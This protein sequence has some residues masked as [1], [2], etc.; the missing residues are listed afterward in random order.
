MPESAV[1][2]MMVECFAGAPQSGKTERLVRRACELAQDGSRVAF[3]CARFGDVVPARERL[4]AYGADGVFA[5]TARQLSLDVLA[6]SQARGLF[7][8]AP[9]VLEPYE[10]QLLLEDLKVSQMRNRRL[11]QVLTYLYAG[12][13]NLSD[14]TWETTP[15]EDVVI[16]RL[17]D[18]LRFYGGVLA[19]EASNL[20]LK[21][22]RLEGAS[23]E[24]AWDFVV[25]DDYGL[26]NRASQ[27]LVRALAGRG[28]V[29]S[30]C[31]RPGL[32]G[33]DE[34]PCYEGAAELV[35]D[36]PQARI[37]VLEAHAPSE[38]VRN[39]LAALCD[40]EA[41]APVFDAVDLPSASLGGGS[42]EGLRE[43][44]PLAID[45]DAH[46]AGARES[47]LQMRPSLES[48]LLTL[49]RASSESIERGE[50]VMIVGTDRL[51][52]RNVRANLA[53]VGLPV[54]ELARDGLKM[55]DFRD[56]RGCAKV[57]KAAVARLSQDRVDD[58]AWRTLVALGDSVGRSAALD[59]LRR[60]FAQGRGNGGTVRLQEALEAL[61]RGELEFDELGEP[62]MEDLLSAYVAAKR[63]LAAPA[64]GDAYPCGDGVGRPS[65]VAGAA[66]GVGDAK[67]A[68]AASAPCPSPSILVCSPQQASGR[69]ADTVL[70]GGF[71]NGL[72]PSRAYFDPAGLAGAARER[73]R[74]RGMRTVFGVASCARD[75]VLFTGFSSCSLQAAETMNVHIASIKLRRGLRTAFIEPSIFSERL[76]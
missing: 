7:G 44:A 26:L 71:V 37:E 10:E 21:A 30:A 32:A 36:S 58:G 49:A 9:R 14:E 56:E 19:C 76:R 73:E 55:R 20:A 47:P 13:E 3:V 5:T 68:E 24:P 63:E 42:V 51:W 25:V 60:V 53:R 35:R 52:R 70:F 18:N 29:V 12:W 28:L 40:D 8:R 15:E 57:R 64:D 2:K 38:Q 48:E 39:V 72:I 66:H 43:P 1:D 33:D 67:G 65:G 16:A 27:H 69:H 74:D 11:R 17:D 23:P 34:Y 45:G 46:E 22:L 6:T 59:R 54:R 31:T 62:L 41:L 50:D 4:A 61:E 75:R